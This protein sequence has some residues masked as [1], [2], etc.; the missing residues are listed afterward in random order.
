MLLKKSLSSTISAIFLRR[1]RNPFDQ[2]VRTQSRGHD[3]MP[4]VD[5][6][7]HPAKV[8][9]DFALLVLAAA[10]LLVLAHG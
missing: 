9:A 10:V 2:L 1:S 4:T 7:A 8:E 6:L 5:G 3:T